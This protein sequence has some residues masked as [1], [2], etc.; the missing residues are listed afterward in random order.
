M[1]TKTTLKN[2]GFKSL[3]AGKMKVTAGGSGKMTSFK[4]VGDQKPG[5]TGVTGSGGSKSV[6]AAS[7]GPGS[8]MHKFTG[9][10]PQK[11]GRTSVA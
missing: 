11:S 10:K 6:Q 4:P 2:K 9:V 8:K 1:A 7:T 5:V 3:D